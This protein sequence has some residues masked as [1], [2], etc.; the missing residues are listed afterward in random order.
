M[1]RRAPSNGSR[2][3]MEC[4]FGRRHTPSVTS[5]ILC[6]RWGRLFSNG[7]G[8][9]RRTLAWAGA[10]AAKLINVWRRCRI[11]LR[12]CRGFRFRQLRIQKISH[13]PQQL[14]LPAFM[15][16]LSRCSSLH[17]FSEDLRRISLF[18]FSRS[19][20]IFW[21]A[22]LTSFGGIRI[23]STSSTAMPAII[24]NNFIIIVSMKM[25]WKSNS[26]QCSFC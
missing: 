8:R 22:V 21:F 20:A 7:K 6:E 10:L 13:S 25:I 5:P 14:V 26:W 2:V 16:F 4:F 24:A 12:F 11:Q 17:L 23:P 18:V 9:A 1:V 15:S 3:E 19:C